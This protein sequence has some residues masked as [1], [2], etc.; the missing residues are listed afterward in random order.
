MEI[1]TFELGYDAQKK[2][3]DAFYGEHLFEG[4]QLMH[5]HLESCVRTLI[6]CSGPKRESTE[7]VHVQNVS[8]G[9]DLSQG[10]KC[11]YVLGIIDKR[12]YDK[13][14][15]LNTIGNKMVHNLH[16]RNALKKDPFIIREDIEKAFRE[17]NDLSNELLLQA[18]RA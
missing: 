10:V 11:L 18:A 16:S 8:E 9:I 2:A 1:E 4:V 3:L 17:A 12:Q 5:G 6:F 14:Q 7:F 15:H 13:A